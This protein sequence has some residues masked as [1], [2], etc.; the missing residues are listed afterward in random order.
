MPTAVAPASLPGPFDDP[1]PAD[2]GLTGQ[3]ARTLLRRDA[4]AVLR[5]VVTGDLPPRSFHPGF[6]AQVRRVRGE[7][8]P[9]DRTRLLV[10]SFRRESFHGG[11]ARLG[12]DPVRT[13]Y[14]LRWVELSTGRRLPDWAELAMAVLAAV[15]LLP[16]DHRLQYRL[17]D[18]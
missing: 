11:A 9:I 17:G 14:A 2:A 3:R 6:A 8:A 7:L 10:E 16:D 13:A 18:R 5:G 12:P 1:G 4:R 15:P